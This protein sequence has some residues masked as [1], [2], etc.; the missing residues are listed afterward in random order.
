MRSLALAV[1]FAAAF[2]WSVAVQSNERV[3]NCVRPDGDHI[4][5]MEM[6]CPVGGEKLQGMV[7]GS[8]STYGVH[9]DWEPVSYLSFPLPLPICPSNGF[10]H[11]KE[12]YT[13]ADLKRY[14]RVI[15][16]EPYKKIYAQK[17]ASYYLLSRFLDLAG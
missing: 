4:V 14:A 10:V 17:H 13:D 8:Y 7:F 16:S 9:L 6:V 2:S 11:H 3:L 12:T 5:S 15:S 1:V